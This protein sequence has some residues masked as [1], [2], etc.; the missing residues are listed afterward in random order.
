MM[1]SGDDAIICVTIPLLCVLKHSLLTIKEDALEAEH[2]EMEQVADKGG[3]IV[4]WP[5]DMYAK[6]AKWQLSNTNCYQVLPFDPS[7]V[8]K[9]K[10]DRLLLMAKCSNILTKEF[11][12]LTT[13][14]RVEPTLYLLPK[15]HKSIQEPP[16][17]SIPIPQV[18]GIGRY[19]RYR[20]SDTEIRYFC[21]IGYRYRIHRDV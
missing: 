4:L 20:N 18:S 7:V 13:Q 10:L 14:H 11:T 1:A 3:N 15:I 6:E 19:L 17:L 5:I 21:G 9:K 16:V 12:F 8:F 2:D